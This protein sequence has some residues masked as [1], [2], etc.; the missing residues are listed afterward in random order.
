MPKSSKAN[1]TE[2]QL[3]DYLLA[4]HQTYAAVVERMFSA[5]EISMLRRYAL[6][7]NGAICYVSTQ[8]GAGF[9][10]LAPP[11]SGIATTHSRARIEDMFVRA[12]AALRNVGPMFAGSGSDVTIQGLT[13]EGAFPFRLGSQSSDIRFIDVRFKAGDWSRDVLWAELYGNRT[14]EF[15]SKENAAARARSS[16]DIPVALFQLKEAQK[17]AI[18]LDRYLTAFKQRHVLI[19][20]DYGDE[21]LKRLMAISSVVTDAGYVP[22]LIK[23]LTDP[24]E[25]NLIQKVVAVGA[26]ARFVVMDDSS[27]SGHLVEWAHPKMN[28]WIVLVLRLEG[29]DS[30]YMTRGATATSSVIR[31]DTYTA[32]NL[33]LV[34]PNAMA[35]AE[36]RIAEL[37][38]E[39]A[40]TYPWR[41]DVHSPDPSAQP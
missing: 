35:W 12:P 30:S 28:D 24:P 13:L 27:K 10:Y 34:L 29:S 11:A 21:G 17:R 4:Y 38:R 32:S 23:D 14:A 18:S 39:F 41:S 3:R 2:D 16:D 37:S 19:L 15:W 25:M 40:D 36:T 22:V 9:E 1:V 7:S 8:F 26:V 5:E 20:G 31:E 33:A 6:L